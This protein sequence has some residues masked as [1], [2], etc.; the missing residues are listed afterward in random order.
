M[1]PRLHDEGA[2]D[3]ILE[4]ADIA[5][6]AITTQ[7]DKRVFADTPNLLRRSA[8]PLLFVELLDEVLDQ[9]RNIVHPLS[10]GGQPDRHDVQTVEE[11]LA[12][13]SVGDSLLEIAI[14]RGN[15]PHIRANLAIGTHRREP[16]LLQDAQQLDLHRSADVADLVEEERAPFG[17]LELADVSLVRAR[18]G[19]FLVTEELTLDQI[20]GNGSAIQSDERP[21]LAGAV[22]VNGACDE[23]L[24]RAVLTADEY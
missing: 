13:L 11:V 21:I 16:S 19:S 18:E 5:R 22:E 12:E 20:L 2:L 7:R 10:Q 4:F 1:G 8:P 23:L 15:N 14:R 3:R 17:I 6:P 9:R 24:A